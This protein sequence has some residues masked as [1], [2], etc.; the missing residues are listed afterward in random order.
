MEE[1]SFGDSF[2]DQGNN[3][4][5]NTLGKGNYL[6]YFEGGKP[7]GRYTNGRTL[8]DL[9]AKAL[10]VKDYLP[11]SLDPLIKDNDLQ[12]GVSFASGGSGFDPL[13]TTITT[14]IPM[15]V[16]LDMFKKYIGRF[17]STIEEEAA[18]NIITNSVVVVVAGNN[19]LFLSLLNRKPQYDVTTYSNMLV[20][21][22]LDFIQDLHTLGVRRIVV[23]SAPP[24]GCLPGVRTISGGLLRNCG[25]Q[26]NNAAQ[27]Y[28]NILKQQLQFWASSFP[29][30]RVAFVD[31]YNTLL[32]IIESPHNYGFDVADKGCCGL[33]G[34][35]EVIYLCNKL[36][37]TCPDDS[38][39][40]FWDGAH[41]TEK[42]YSII[43]NHILQDLVNT[44]L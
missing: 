9:L 39:Y 23:F 19:D 4:Y 32:S 13:T 21:L 22:V 14:A 31:Y 41:P 11:P 24:I 25:D 20:N 35:I 10:G 17:K 38:K 29:Q 28:N 16:Q 15:S 3:N 34:E 5:V 18:N 42:G 43:V 33:T 12:T 26:E 27:L 8:S 36:T 2:V 44:L 30:S 1:T 6:P 40:L 37:P 7:T